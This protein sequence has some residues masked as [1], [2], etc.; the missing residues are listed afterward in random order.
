MR[1]ER[2]KVHPITD[3]HTLITIANRLERER[4]RELMASFQ[5]YLFFDEQTNASFVGHVRV[6]PLF[7]DFTELDKLS[8]PLAANVHM[9]EGTQKNQPSLNQGA[10]E[11]KTHTHTSIHLFSF[12][13]IFQLAKGL[14]RDD[15]KQFSNEQGEMFAAQWH[16]HLANSISRPM[17]AKASTRW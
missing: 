2:T 9:H 12:L 13:Y 15:E 3:A 14:I 1:V 10:A 7:F 8:R 5:F 4:E 16:Q 17:T 11:E 6:S